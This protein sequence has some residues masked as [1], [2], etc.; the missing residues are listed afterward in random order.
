MRD[1]QSESKRDLWYKIT[2]SRFSLM[3][4]LI[5]LACCG[6]VALLI[7]FDQISYVLEW[8]VNRLEEKIAALIESS[9]QYEASTNQLEDYRERF[10]QLRQERTSGILDILNYR[11]KLLLFLADVETFID[12]LESIQRGYIAEII[13]IMKQVMV[14]TAASLSWDAA[15]QGMKLQN[16]DKV[17]TGDASI[18]EISTESGNILRVNPESMII[19][20]DLSRDRKTFMPREVFSIKDTDHADFNVRTRRADLILEDAR[21]QINI[22]QQSDVKVLKRERTATI[23]VYAGLVEVRND[24]GIYKEL[25]TRDALSISP[26]GVFLETETIPYPP[27][28]TEPLNLKFFRFKINE[29]ADVLLKWQRSENINLY[30]LQVATDIDFNN[31]IIEEQINALQ[32]QLK[33]LSR[34]NYFWRVA[35]I[36]GVDSKLM[37]EFTPTRSFLVTFDLQSDDQTVTPP[38]FIRLEVRAISQHAVLVE[39]KAS[40]GVR[41]LADGNNISVSDDGTFKDIIPFDTNTGK[42]LELQLFDRHGNVNRK[43]VRPS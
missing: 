8:R 4:I 33:Q 10:K 34:G 7:Y 9:R 35:S 5:F 42:N 14:S 12:N 25:R 43:A 30:R 11:E 13:R 24:Q 39:G 2:I 23:S 6:I 37:S 41:L 17:K 27:D 15:H 22:R 1:Q 18:A 3:L 28:L 16:G 40:P 29:P 31:K 32:Y 36:G 38:T 20:K 21:A 19:V 26:S